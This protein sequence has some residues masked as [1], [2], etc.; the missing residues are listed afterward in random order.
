MLAGI[1]Q[2]KE[3]HYYIYIEEEKDKNTISVIHSNKENTKCLNEE[4]AKELLKTILSSALTYQEKQG[5]YDVY[6]DEADNKRYFKNGKENYN[7]FFENNGI[8]A[9]EYNNPLDKLERIAKRFIISVAPMIFSFTLGINMGKLIDMPIDYK[10]LDSIP[11]EE[12]TVQDAIDEIPTEV[13]VAEEQQEIIPEEPIVEEQPV[14][15]NF[16]ELES[17][18]DE[19]KSNYGN[20]F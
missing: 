6:L 14:E 8:S 10:V 18:P 3:N 9:I 20:S 1:I 12:I 5:E 13:P 15:E 2:E 16:E 7:L 11:T 4:E 19:D 17:P